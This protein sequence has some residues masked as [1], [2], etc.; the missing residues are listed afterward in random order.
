MK[1]H[2]YGTGAGGGIPCP[3]CKCDIC[4]RALAEGGMR[5]RCCVGINEDILLDFPIEIRYFTLRYG[6]DSAKISSVFFTHSHGDHLNPMDLTL[7]YGV[8]TDISADNPLCVYGNSAVLEKLGGWCGKRADYRMTRLEAF[9]EYLVG[10]VTV[11]PLTASHDETEEC[12][13]FLVS[14]GGSTFLYC[15]DTDYPP[16][17][18]LEFLGRCGIKIRL[19]L[20]DC[21]WGSD[22][23][24]GKGHMGLLQIN[25]LRE[26]LFEKGIADEETKFGLTHFSHNHFGDE[27]LEAARRQGYFIAEDGMEYDI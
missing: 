11:T 3:F 26:F 23:V 5:C 25:R 16:A 14:Q 12:F 8:K 2:I 15:T 20:F 9:G 19:A 4:A 27:L 21:T 10:D 1:I 22:E 24:V 13:V 17:E 18:T 7:N 6:L